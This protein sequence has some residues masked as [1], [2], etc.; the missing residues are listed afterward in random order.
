MRKLLWLFLFFM[1]AF[2]IAQNSPYKFFKLD[3]GELVFENIYTHDSL[4]ADQM[5]AM[6]KKEVPKIQGFTDFRSDGNLITGRLQNSSINYKKAGH[7][8]FTTSG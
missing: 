2:A 7:K 4:N 8:H 6:L 1:P 3:N 5:G